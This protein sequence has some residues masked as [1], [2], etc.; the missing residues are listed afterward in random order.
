MKFPLCKLGKEAHHGTHT[1]G[2]FMSYILKWFYLL[3]TLLVRCKLPMV[4]LA[5]T[6]SKSP[7]IADTAFRKDSNVTTHNVQQ[8]TP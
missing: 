3:G 6:F 4:L 1:V 8:S 5:S 2:N 7:I